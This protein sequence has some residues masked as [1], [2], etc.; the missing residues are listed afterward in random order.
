MLFN[1]V[2]R[3]DA[4]ADAATRC[5]PPRGARRDSPAAA[6]PDP[7]C[8]VCRSVHDMRARASVL[9]RH[10]RCAALMRADIAADGCH[11][12]FRRHLMPDAAMP[13][14]FAAAM[15]PISSVLHAR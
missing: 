6:R 13:F 4:I 2:L 14:R 12:H 15:L 7:R 8:A 3:R 11:F 5:Q 1:G 10:I 9:R